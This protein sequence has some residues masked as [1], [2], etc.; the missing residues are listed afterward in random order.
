LFGG[1]VPSPDTVT[2]DVF[3]AR[4]AQVDVPVQE[5]SVAVTHSFSHQ[6]YVLTYLEIV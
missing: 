5:V 3:D 4:G 2:H 1:Q 6:S